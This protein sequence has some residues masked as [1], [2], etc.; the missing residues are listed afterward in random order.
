MKLSIS[1][2]STLHDCPRKYWYSYVIKVK[3]KKSEGF[4][5][6]SAV[7]EG[8]ENYYNKK[9]PMDGVKTILFGKK[10]DI[11]EEARAGVDPYKLLKDARKIFDIYKQKAPDWKPMF[12]ELMFDVPI[13]NPKTGQRLLSRLIGKIDLITTNAEVIDHKTCSGGFSTF[14]EV[15]NKFQSAGYIY[16]YWHKFKKLPTSFI[17]NNIIRGN[18]RHEPKVNPIPFEFNEDTLIWFFEEMQKAE[19]ELENPNLSLTIKKSHCRF[20]QYKDICEFSKGE[21]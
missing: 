13:I 12:V 20:C 4:Y 3:S 11:G 10:T 19:Q 1:R 9:D 6:G 8:L 7:H 21:I 15:K 16:C 17:F 2:V 14:W 18:T 5:F